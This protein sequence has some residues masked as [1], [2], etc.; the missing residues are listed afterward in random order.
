MNKFYKIRYNQKIVLEFIRHHK[1]GI[2][3]FLSHINKL[4]KFGYTNFPSQYGFLKYIYAICSNPFR[5]ILL[6]LNFQISF[7]GKEQDVWV[8]K[9]LNGMNNGFFVDLAATS[10]IIENNTYL[11]EKKFGWY[12]IVIEPNLNYYKKLILN[13]SCICVNYPVSSKAEEV[14]FVFNRGIGGI[15]S[16]FTDNSP[17]KRH[18]LITKLRRKGAV[19][20]LKTKTLSEILKFYDAPNVIDYLSLDIEGSEYDALKDFP[21]NE[22]RF[23]LLTVER[24]PAVLCQLLFDNDYLFVKNHK[25]DTFFAHK[26]CVD[27]FKISLEPFVQ[28]PPKS[29]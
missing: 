3:M 6:S 19:H 25:V 27:K 1:L 8:I 26:L 20:F 7:S 22:Y 21:F 9:T 24:P 16:E 10:G 2:F 23:N 13:R 17:I 15:I 29:W 4:K 18:N 5:L 11:L 28:L 14:E 12:G